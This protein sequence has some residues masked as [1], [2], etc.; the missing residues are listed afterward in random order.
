MYVFKISIKPFCK[1]VKNNMFL[2]D[3]LNSKHFFHFLN[4]KFSGMNPLKQ[5]KQMTSFLSPQNKNP[6]FHKTQNFCQIKL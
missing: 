1:A 4:K 2:Q 3:K 5:P 6:D